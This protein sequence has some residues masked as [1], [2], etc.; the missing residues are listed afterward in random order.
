MVKYFNK[1][2]WFKDKKREEI[3][4]STLNKL[5]YFES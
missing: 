5:G 3:N 4:F 2:G 1:W